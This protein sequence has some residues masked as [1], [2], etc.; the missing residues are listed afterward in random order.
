MLV[1][2]NEIYESELIRILS[3][4]TRRKETRSA[5]LYDMIFGKL[6]RYYKFKKLIY[7]TDFKISFLRALFIYIFPATF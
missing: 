6:I 3:T 4:R 5:S 1:L 7:Q 2:L